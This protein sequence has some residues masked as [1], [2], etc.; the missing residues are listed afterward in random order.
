M[1]FG[2]ATVDNDVCILCGQL[3]VPQRRRSAE[4]LAGSYLTYLGQCLPND[5]RIKYFCTYSIEYICDSCG[6][7]YYTP[8]IVGEGDF[9]AALGEMFD[10]Y[11][12]GG[13]DKGLAIDFLARLEDRPRQILEIGSGEGLFLEQLMQRGLT[14]A[15]V[16][17]NE[18]AVK[19]AQ[20]KGLQV[21]LPDKLQLA[22]CD[23]LCAFQTIEHLANPVSLL[24]EYISKYSPRLTI[25]SAPCFE[26]LLGY[27]TDPLVWPPHHITAWSAKGFGTLAKLLGLKIEHIW[28]QPQTFTEFQDKQKREVKGRIPGIPY[29]PNNRFGHFAFRLAQRMR[30]HWANRAHSI[31]VALG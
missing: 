25:L 12:Q 22:N 1:L 9:Y 27:T 20:C 16:D 19:A 14:G 4:E 6:V 11:Y 15:G 28:Y 7:R 8:S 21:A 2:F 13:W 3:G 30:L 17:I 10:W 24:R 26:T 5:I 31:M 29:L 23:I 18:T